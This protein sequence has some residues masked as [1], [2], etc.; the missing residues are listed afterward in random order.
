MNLSP[1]V[2]IREPLDEFFIS[3]PSQPSPWAIVIG[4][5]VLIVF[6]VVRARF[7]R[8]GVAQAAPATSGAATG[9]EDDRSP[10]TAALGV[11]DELEGEWPAGE[12]EL[13]VFSV[14]LSF[15]VRR[16]VQGRFGVR[17]LERATDELVDSIREGA[18]SPVQRDALGALLARCDQVKFAAALRG[19]AAR[20]A[21]ECARALL[22]RAR[23]FVKG[24]AVEE[25]GAP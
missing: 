13:D 5:L 10:H 1:A 11:L 23:D 17:A 8:G 9:P 15:V 7:R 12:R 20:D 18:L 16:Y 3:F 22:A 6:V 4:G 19:D 14:R 2:P 25:G 21:P 24:T